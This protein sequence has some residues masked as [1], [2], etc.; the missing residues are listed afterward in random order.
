MSVLVKPRRQ[1][2]AALQPNLTRGCPASAP[3]WKLAD[4][5]ARAGHGVKPAGREALV[6]G[7]QPV[8][9]VILLDIA[10]FDVHQNNGAIEGL[11][12]AERR[13]GNIRVCGDQIQLLFV[14]GGQ[15]LWGLCFRREARLFQRADFVSMSSKSIRRG[16]R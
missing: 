3:R 14:G 2:T 10:G 7:K 12:T 8:D 15:N 5:D 1:R 9:R 13:I 11:C 6:S 16:L 4:F